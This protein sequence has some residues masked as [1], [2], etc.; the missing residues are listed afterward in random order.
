MILEG[1]P[2]IDVNRSADFSGNF[3]LPDCYFR[4]VALFV[5]GSASL[6]DDEFVDSKRVAA[7]LGAFQLA[8][9]TPSVVGAQVTG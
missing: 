1:G 9:V 6:K 7:F 4:P 2:A 5:A 8:V 3:S